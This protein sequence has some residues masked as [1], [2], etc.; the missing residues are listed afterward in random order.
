MRGGRSNISSF[1]CTESQGLRI[2]G[3]WQKAELLPGEQLKSPWSINILPKFTLSDTPDLI[4]ERGLHT[5]E[6]GS[7]TGSN[8][9][10]LIRRSCRRVPWRVWDISFNFSASL[11][12]KACDEDRVESIFAGSIS[13]L[14]DANRTAEKP[15][16]FLRSK[17]VAAVFFSGAVEWFLS[18]D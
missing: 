1:Q 14:T 15:S 2:P 12:D 6:A 8:A 11:P 7:E 5:L 13:S 3:K 17:L 10:W 9:K 18:E 16:A 4:S